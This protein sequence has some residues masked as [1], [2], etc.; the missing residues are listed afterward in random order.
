ML[1]EYLL[2]CRTGIWFS[3]DQSTFGQVWPEPSPTPS[4]SV[5]TTLGADAAECGAP[6]SGDPAGL[7]PEP[8]N[9]G[10]G[11][12]QGVVGGTT[13]QSV[14]RNPSKS[15]GAVKRKQTEYS[16]AH[17]LPRRTSLLGKHA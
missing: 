11:R 1:C 8:L 14:E 13:K 3:E 6:G 4:P 7:A 15:E 17:K 16:T 10:T 2:R 5:S 9:E 12:E